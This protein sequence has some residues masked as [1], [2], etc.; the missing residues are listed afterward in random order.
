[1]KD[2]QAMTTTP[3]TNATPP[4]SPASLTKHPL[5]VFD[6]QGAIPPLET[7]MKM[8]RN[9][10]MVRLWDDRSLKLQRS[11]RIGFCVTSHGEEATQLGVAAA[12]RDNDWLFPAYR[13]HGLAMWRGVSLLD[14]AA[15]LYGSADDRCEGKQMPCHW[16][17]ADKYFASYSSV[18]GTQIVHATGA[19]MAAQISGNPE[20]L[21]VTFFGDGSTSANDFHSA[22]NLA[23][24][25]KAP[26]LFVCVNNQ[27]A[28][29]LPVEKQTASE[30][31]AIKGSA[32][33][34]PGVRVDGNDVLAV[35]QAVLAMADRARKGEGP[36]LLELL[37][38]RVHPHSSSDDPS[39]YRATEG[40]EAWKSF[41]P[42]QR[43]EAYLKYHHAM[44]DEALQAIWEA[45]EKEVYEATD[46]AYK[47]APPAWETV[48]DDV[49]SEL[50]PQLEEQK[51]ELLQ[52]ETGLVLAHAGAFPL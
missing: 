5:Q 2:A 30:T 14:L 27:W 35:Y 47:V 24:V 38:Y 32:Y 23:G 37:T 45:V 21:A 16:S 19:A 12:L 41:D 34:M 51:A 26:A 9:M 4:E 52:H 42:I 44:T 11:G 6:P 29:S 33:G 10:V 8:H 15:Q 17:F 7:I 25:R 46:E 43:L 1:V 20:Q 36:A 40:V 3:N 13:Q 31:I 22:L 48:F 28:I 50:T 18:I 49:Y 39:R